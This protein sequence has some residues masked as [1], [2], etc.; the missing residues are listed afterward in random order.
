MKI[1]QDRGLLARLLFGIEGVIG[2][3]GIGAA[4]FYGAAMTT[5]NAWVAFF[6]ILIPFLPLWAL[7]CYGAYRGLTSDNLFQRVLFWLFVTGHVFV[8]PVGTVI[9]GAL[10]WLRREWR[11][12]LAAVP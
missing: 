1:I 12:G 7:F 11:K 5:G 8:F 9:S 2:A 3:F 4:A 6:G 10:I